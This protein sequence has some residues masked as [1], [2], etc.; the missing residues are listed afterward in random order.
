MAGFRYKY[1]KNMAKRNP[2][3]VY[4]N[5]YIKVFTFVLTAAAG[6]FAGASAAFALSVDDLFTPGLGQNNL[7]T[8]ADNMT[9]SSA[10][11]PGLVA[12]LS[13]LLGLLFGVAG[14]FKLKEHVENPSQAPIGQSIV[15]LLIGGALFALPT[16]YGAV[17]T[18]IAGENGLATFTPAGGI[19]VDISGAFG[20]L[21][22][23]IGNLTGGNINFVL[24]TIIASVS[25][26]PGLISAVA[27]LLGL[28]F[29]VMGLLKIKEHVDSP[30]QV[31]LK[32]PVFRLLIAG[33]LF[34][35][36]TIYAAMDNLISGGSG[37][38]DVGNISDIATIAQNAGTCGTSVAPINIG[39]DSGL[40]A[41]L[42]RLTAATAAFPAFLS[43]ISYLFGLILG[44]WGILKIKEHVE[45]PQQVDIFQPVSRL[46]AG[47]AFFSLP[48]VVEVIKNT[49]APETVAS[50]I[51]SITDAIDAVTNL[52]NQ[53]FGGGAAGAA[54]SCEG[55]DRALICFVQDIH[56]PF[57][58]VA[59]FFGLVA[60]TIL[61]M[62]GISR[63]TKSA[64]EGARGPGGIGTMMTFLAGGALV[65]FNPLIGSFAE[66]FFGASGSGYEATGDLMYTD[67]MNADEIARVELVVSAILQFMMIVGIVS[68]VRGIFIVREVSE[69]SSQASMMAGITHLV[70]GALAANLGTL[71]NAVQATLRITDYGIAFS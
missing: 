16:I 20:A 26:I 30:T 64:Q 70:G 38:S 33:A 52:V 68:F 11:L 34:A 69:G 32:E 24:G 40:G 53:V 36:P 4:M 60:G 65:S 1:G 13:Y 14:I 10:S 39:T 37:P 25:N 56:G 48:F 47:G 18:T 42:C 9:G 19:G 51:D 44:L 41:V 57:G 49:I 62:I 46:V 23:I 45:N 8:I 66:S 7:S 28:I 55:L 31:T 67:G 54:D 63:L 21:S 12:A 27:Y 6:Y 61:I 15:R 17:Y 5:R 29:G 58:V 35:L 59:T 22:G 50:F 71:M 2:K 3:G 43:A